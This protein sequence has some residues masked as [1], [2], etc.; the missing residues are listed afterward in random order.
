MGWPQNPG[1]IVG[2]ALLAVVLVFVGWQIV[3][4][5]TEDSATRPLV[6]TS[7]TVPPHAVWILARDA[8]VQAC[9]H[10]YEDD[11]V[12]QRTGRGKPDDILQWEF[13]EK[14]LTGVVHVCFDEVLAQVG[15]EPLQ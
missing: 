13:E 14:Y 3:Q 11:Y 15:P 1:H 6:A 8:L 5:R 9:A 7:P 2:Y 4:D 10:R 12:K